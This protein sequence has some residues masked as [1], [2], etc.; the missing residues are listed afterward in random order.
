[1]YHFLHAVVLGVL[2][3][4]P[5]TH[6]LKCLKCDS[7]TEPRL[8]TRLETCHKG[9]VCG[10]RQRRSDNGDISYWTGCVPQTGC[11]VI[12]T[13]KGKRTSYYDNEII[14]QYCCSG[15][16]CNSQGCGA[17][18]YPSDRGPLCY[19][20]KNIADPSTCHSIAIC[21]HNEKC[22]VGT[23]SHFGHLYYTTRCE[24]AHTCTALDFSSPLGK[25]AVGCQ[26]CCSGDLCNSGC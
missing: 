5:V 24:T 9:E 8:C 17:R 4:L 10:V 21:N 22:F 16:L 14:C 1:M 26:H 3:S 2:C 7:V 18:G 20:C 23:E 15:D 11:S 12:N 6:G 13:V 19:E 25:R